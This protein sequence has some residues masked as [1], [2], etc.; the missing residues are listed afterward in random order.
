MR[1]NFSAKPFKVV[2]YRIAQAGRRFDMAEVERLAGRTPA[3][4]HRC[5]VVGVHATP[6]FAEL[7]RIAGLVAAGPHPNPVPHAHVLTTPTRKTPGGPR[8]D[9]VHSVMDL[10]RKMNS[11]VPRAD[12]AACPSMPSR[13]RLASK[14]AARP[15]FTEWQARTLGGPGS[16]LT[17]C[18][19]PTS[20]P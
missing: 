13:P 12:R 19:S 14:L 8:G 17:G 9:V 7:R 3:Y 18:R 2:P 1:V 16:S 4:A 15:D 6:D 10:A 20:V 5:R 11:A